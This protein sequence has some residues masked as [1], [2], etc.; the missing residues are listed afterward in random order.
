MDINY[1]S[2]KLSKNNIFINI[3]EA[4]LKPLIILNLN[5]NKF[6]TLLMFDIDAV[7]GNKIHWLVINIRNNDIYTGNILIEYKGPAPPIGSGIHH[8]TF[9]LFE[10]TEF[11]KIKNIKCKTRFIELKKLFKKIGV[12]KKNFITRIIKYFISENK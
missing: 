7:G 11:I 2:I 3:E 4:N 9:V 12:N 5:L 10:Q 6:Y 8:Y 1:K